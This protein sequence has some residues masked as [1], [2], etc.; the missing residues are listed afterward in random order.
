MAKGTARPA[1]LCE[2]GNH[3]WANLT[4]GF[5]GMVS[6]CDK[7]LLDANSWRASPR[8]WV[9]H[10]V[11]A[12]GNGTYLHRAVMGDA[13]DRSVDHVNHNGLDN[14]R[15]NLRLA[16]R[17]QNSVN[18]RKRKGTTSQFVGVSYAS[19]RNRWAANLCVNGVNKRLGLFKT[20]EEAASAYRVAAAKAYGDFAASA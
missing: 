19:W 11:Y 20:E 5:V 3:C 4:R 10:T 18:Q 13:G 9:H 1:S 16:T 6:P 17:A 12:A 8:K 15:E 14:R 7:H 2:C